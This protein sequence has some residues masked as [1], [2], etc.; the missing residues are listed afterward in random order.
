[1]TFLLRAAAL[2]L[3]AAILSALLAR[4]ASARDDADDAFLEKQATLDGATFRYRLLVPP[5]PPSGADLEAAARDRHPLVVFLHGAGERG[6]DDRAQLRHFGDRMASPA[7]RARFPAYVLAVQCPKD[8]KWVDVPWSAGSSTPLPDAPS[9]PM[10]RVIAA[11][12]K[13][14]REEPIDTSRIY[15]TGLSMGG[16]GTFDLAERHPDWFAA[17][18]AVCGGGDEREAGRLVSLPLS[19]WHGDADRAVPVARSRAMVDAVRALGGDVEYHELPGVDHDSWNQAYGEDGALSWLFAR[20]NPS[21]YGRTPG[22]EL[23]RGGHTAFGERECLV[24]LGDSITQAGVGPRG[25]ATLL[26]EAIAAGPD[27]ERVQVVGAGISG[28]KVPDLEERFDRDV[29]AK[30]PTVVFVYIGI[31]DVWHGAL[32]GPE[33][34]TPPERFESGMRSLV[35][36]IEALGATAVLATPSLIGEKQ[37]G[38]NPLDETLDQ[39][40]AITRRIAAERGLVLC[41][42][43]R[44]FVDHVDVF[45]AANADRGLLTT[46]GVHLN[47]AGNRLVA[48]RA[49]LAIREAVAR[50]R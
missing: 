47:D 23:L 29:A 24:F 16:F 43:R 25:Y 4:A 11:L 9:A 48:D 10:R 39:Y 30:S 32:F 14:L 17:A 50:R 40:A 35:D 13:T 41:D 45:H 3:I 36:R 26:R 31:N 38:A 42:L 5:P 19:V 12:K 7:Y 21:G 34:A 6:D 18:L 44:A 49:A 46:D 8:E 22:L 20:S 27:A 15:L 1:M 2:L 37:D 28:H 33:R